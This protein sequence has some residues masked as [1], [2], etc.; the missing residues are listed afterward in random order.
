MKF[1]DINECKPKQGQIVLIKT[2][3]EDFAPYCVCIYSIKEKTGLFEQ[4]AQGIMFWF[5]REV[6]GWIPIED[7]E[8]EPVHCKDCVKRYNDILCPL[9]QMNETYNEDDGHD[10]FYTYGESEDDDF[11]CAEGELEKDELTNSEV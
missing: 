5:E 9:V 2:K 7:I 6:Q 4:Y 8:K 3:E 1:I 11:F 10:Y